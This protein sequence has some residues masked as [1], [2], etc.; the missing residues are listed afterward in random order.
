MSFEDPEMLARSLEV[1]S[2]LYHT[3]VGPGTLE[4]TLALEKVGKAVSKVD[5][6]I[7]NTYDGICIRQDLWYGNH[8]KW[9]CICGA[10]LECVELWHSFPVG[11]Q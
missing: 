1:F 10:C 3:L 8:G 9:R 11:Y 5:A 6:A 2:L 4:I 7:E